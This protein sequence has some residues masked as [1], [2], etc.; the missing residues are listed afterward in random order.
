MATFNGWEI[1]PTPTSPAGPATIDFTAVDTVAISISPFTGQQ[2]VQNWNASYLEASVSMP[3]LTHSKAQDWIAFLL[4]L[5]GV[6][7]VFQMGDPLGRSP[8]GSAAGAPVVSGSDQKGR[9]VLTSGWTPN[10]AG[11][12]LRGDW[13]QLGYRLYRAVLPSD[14]DALGNATVRFW[15]QLRESPTDGLPLIL[16]NTVGLW[17]LK[18]NSRQWSETQSR[19]YGMQ[20]DIREAL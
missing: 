4:S 2:Q 15:P 5:E 19:T 18:S 16:H 1:I 13:V 12:L 7:H 14:A 20:F 3:A 10:A 17:R 8:R 11:V 6:A 9:S